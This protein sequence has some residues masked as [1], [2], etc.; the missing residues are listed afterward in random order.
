MEGR[1][2]GVQGGEREM[3]KGKRKGYEM[4]GKE[5]RG[6]GRELGK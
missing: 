1:G 2:G 6:V 4:S 3:G 5:T